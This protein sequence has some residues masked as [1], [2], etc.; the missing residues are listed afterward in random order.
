MRLL[1]VVALFLGW[2]ATAAA[3]PGDPPIVLIA[4]DSGAHV[5]ADP[6]GIGVRLTCPD[7]R[8]FQSSVFTDFGDYSDYEVVFAT[9]PDLAADGRLI[10]ANVVD[11]NVPTRSAAGPDQCASA[12]ANTT[13]GKPGP[14]V[15]PGTYYWQADRVC[16]GCPSG[17]ETSPVRSFAVHATLGLRFAVPKRAFGGYPIIATVRAAGVPDGGR[18]TV[19]RRAGRRWKRVAVAEVRDEKGSVVFTLPT[20]RRRVRLKATVGAQTGTSP[21]RTVKVA[22]ARG[23]STTGDVGHYRG[24][25]DGARLDLDVAGGGRQ[26]RDF[27]TEVSMFCVGPT[28]D[29]NRILIGIAP[30]KR[31]KVAPDGRFYARSRHGRS[32]VIE[33]R[34]RVRRGRVK[35]QVRLTAGT[36]DGTAGF[37]AKLRR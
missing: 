18:V 30:V 27:K 6:D 13:V 4:P 36:C 37:S 14:E 34:G 21:V 24:K 2:P 7:Y 11:R 17:F 15:T 32:T 22:R 29:Q 20:G 19:Q 8:K 25:A 3:L 28:P 33:L 12:M 35:G 9:R 5:P 26:I 16:T 1:A 10:D 31:A 23:W